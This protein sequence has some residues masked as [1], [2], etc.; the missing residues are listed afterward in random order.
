MP[1]NTWRAD[2][3]NLAALQDRLEARPSF[4]ATVPYA[5]VISDPVV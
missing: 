2:Y 1:E 4:Q 5:Q 3:P